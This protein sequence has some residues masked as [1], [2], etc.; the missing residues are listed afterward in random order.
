MITEKNTTRVIYII[1][2]DKKE[3]I[4]LGRGHESDIRLSDISVSR[5]HAVIKREKNGRLVIKD[6]ESKF[7]TLILVQNPKLPVIKNNILQIQVGRVCF[8]FSLKATSCIFSCFNSNSSKYKGCDYQT[9]NAQH[10]TFEKTNFIKVQNEYSLCADSDTNSIGDN[11]DKDEYYTVKS[12]NVQPAFFK[13]VN[14]DPNIMNES[15]LA[16]DVRD[17]VTRF[18]IERA[19][20]NEFLEVANNVTNLNICDIRERVQR[21]LFVNVLKF[22][23]IDRTI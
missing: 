3:C 13:E 1:D 22:V 17:G 21:D 20:T 16:N 2:L 7:G 14:D 12:P 6:N 11:I 18:K 8:M 10:V 19:Y 9:L 5:F 15:I 4:R 23:L